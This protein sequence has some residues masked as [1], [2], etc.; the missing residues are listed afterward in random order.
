MMPETLR[1]FIAVPIPEALTV[2]LRHVQTQLQ[3]RRM[4]LRWV[5]PKNI[6]LTLKFLGD[7]ALSQVPAIVERMDAAADVM[8]AFRLAASGVGVFPNHRHPRVLWVGLAGDLIRLNRLQA[9]L[10]HGLVAEGF[11]KVSRNFQAHLTIGRTRQRID[12]QTI[13]TTLI[14]LQDIVSDSFRVDRLDLVKSVLKPAGPEYT[15]LHVS[16]LAG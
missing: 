12:A 14:S 3:A 10:D 7:I 11:G 13:D 16:H 4:K 15:R 6:H 8:P 9:T 1:A 5:A 2:F